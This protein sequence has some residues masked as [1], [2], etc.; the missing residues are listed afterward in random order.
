MV[1]T[2][3]GTDIIVIIMKKITNPSYIRVVSYL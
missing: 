3:F 1:M 2:N